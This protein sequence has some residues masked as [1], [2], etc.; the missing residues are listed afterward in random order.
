MFNLVEVEAD[1]KKEAEP[2]KAEAVAEVD[3]YGAPDKVQDL[4]PRR[5]QNRA[6]SN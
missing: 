6:N 5:Y 2:A 3:E 4:M 1:P